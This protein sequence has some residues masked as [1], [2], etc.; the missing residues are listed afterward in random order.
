MERRPGR[1]AVTPRRQSGGDGHHPP[2]DPQSDRLTKVEA[3]LVA[4]QKRM[5]RMEAI[6]DDVRNAWDQMGTSRQEVRERIE[7]DRKDQDV[8][9]NRIAAMQAEIDLLR[10]HEK[11]HQADV[12][13]LRA[14]AAGNS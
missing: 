14:K 6:L 5:A 2:T 4:L 11:A 9:F 8:Q 3:A 13:H 1:T 7:L 10:A 12:D